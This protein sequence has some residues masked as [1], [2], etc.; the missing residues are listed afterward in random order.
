MPPAPAGVLQHLG[1]DGIGAAGAGIQT[2]AAAH[3]SVAG[4]QVHALLLADGQDGLHPVVQLIGHGG[5]LR[6][7]VGVMGDVLLEH[8]GFALEHRDLGGRGAGID[9]QYSVFCHIVISSILF[10]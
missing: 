9:R 4:G 7:L 5:V 8:F 6:Q 10:N 3:E 1:V 2:A